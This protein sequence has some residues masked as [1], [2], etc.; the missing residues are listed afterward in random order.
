MKKL[1]LLFQFSLNQNL[2][3]V[4]LGACTKKTRCDCQGQLFT[5]F[6]F[7]L[8]LLWL[9]GLRTLVSMKVLAFMFERGNPE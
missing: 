6:L 7:L 8:F 4:A 5:R 2:P 9:G 1:N 3:G